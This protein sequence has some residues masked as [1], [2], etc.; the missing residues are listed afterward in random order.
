MLADALSP[1]LREL[2]VNT[3]RFLAADAVEAANSGHPG[4]PLGAADLAFVLWTEFLRLDPTTPSWANRDRFVL[5]GG[6]AS[7]LLYSLLHLSGHALPLD[8]LKRFR[9]WESK[10]PGHPE[11]GHTDGVELTT[12]PLGAGFA[13]SVGMALG[14]KMLAARFNTDEHPVLD[15]HVYGICGDGDMQEGVTAEAASLAGHLGL[16]NLIFI[17]DNNDITIEGHLDVSMGEDVARRFEAYGWYVQQI[18]GHDHTSIRSALYLARKQ[19][20]RPSLI[21]AKTVIGKGAP[22]KAGT[23]DVH[24]SP[25]GKAE[26]AAMRKACNWPDET[27][28]IP[29]A[30]REVWQRRASEGQ[31][32]HTE[33]RSMFETWR[34]QHPDRAALWDTHMARKAPDDVLEQ[35]LAAVGNKSDATRSLSGTVIQKATALMPWLVGGAA[36]LEPSTKTGIKGAASVVRA[37][38]ASDQLA[39]V[40]FAGRNLHFGIREHAMGAISN[41]MVHFGGWLTY[42]ATFLVFSDY[43]RPPVRLA[44][45]SKIPTLFIFTHDSFWVGEDGPT[46]Q[47]I[48]HIASLRLIPDLT[49][50]RPADGVETAAAWAWALAR[51]AGDG[52]NVLCLT[53]QKTHALQRPTAFAPRDVWKGAYVVADV[54]GATPDLVLLATGSEVGPAVEARTLLAEKGVRARVVSVPSVERFKKQDA[55]YRASVLP[56]GV[57]RVA[58]EAGRTDGWY[59]FVG[60]DGLVLGLDHFGHSAPG[61]VLA[62]KFGFTGARVA[63]QVLRWLGR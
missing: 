54:D 35:L 10:T 24:G 45:L 5:S 53:R 56:D 55:A 26:L 12:G 42:C 52:P 58:V 36:D 62:D 37:S 61:E 48:E 2:C 20:T 40:S 28:H 1:Q 44:A 46:H 60:L 25:L 13:T 18:D 31:K 23:H 47:P 19:T 63:E 33:W 15:C 51:P 57:R 8:D 38:V 41:G 6:H 32:A 43:M 49:V 3:I 39:D 9:Q 22:T 17:Y 14:A 34:A 50:W 21:V 27:F 16:G 30:V 4:T 59:Q 7:M 29:T 11:Y